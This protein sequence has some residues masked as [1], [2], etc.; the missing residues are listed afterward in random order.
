MVRGGQAWPGLGRNR[1]GSGSTDVAGH[2]D[3]AALVGSVGDAPA[4]ARSG[5]AIRRG[6]PLRSVA[7]VGI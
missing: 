6:G 2:G 1:I 3:A 5:S 7:Q 4:A